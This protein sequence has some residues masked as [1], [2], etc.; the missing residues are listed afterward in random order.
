MKKMLLWEK[1]QAGINE[2]EQTL[3]SQDV[4]DVVI[5]LEFTK[6]LFLTELFLLI[7]HIGKS[8]EKS[9]LKYEAWITKGKN[10]KETAERLGMTTDGLRATISYFN[11]RLE[12]IVGE[13]TVSRIV[14]CRSQQELSDIENGL[15]SRVSSLN[16][17]YFR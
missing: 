16:K 5:R 7:E 12:N 17:G 9:T 15:C 11:S 8:T 1:I 13:D 14:N 4:T 10:H 2:I 3:R 6:K